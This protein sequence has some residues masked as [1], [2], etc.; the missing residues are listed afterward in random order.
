MKIA[1]LQAGEPRFGEDTDLFLQNLTGF[2]QADWFCYFWKQSA[3]INRQ[4]NFH[5][6]PRWASIDKEW[7]INKLTENLSS[8]HKIVAFELGDQNNIKIPYSSDLCEAGNFFKMHYSLYRADQL[9]QAYEKLNG[10]YDLI[11]RGRPDLALLTEC[12]LVDL[13][14][15]LDKNPTAIIIPRGPMHG[16]YGHQINDVFAIGLS[17]TMQI[18]T[19]L[20]NC[21]EEYNTKCVF[22]P[23]TLLAYHCSAKGISAFFG[24]FDATIRSKKTRRDGVDYIDFGRWA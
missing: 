22:H 21:F 23:E 3:M 24:S 15:F 10:P 11:V 7:A 4:G 16:Y 12:Q 19:N 13:K 14:I 2:D 18:Y 1:I 17:H 8:Q 6:A 5:I 20:I 9:R